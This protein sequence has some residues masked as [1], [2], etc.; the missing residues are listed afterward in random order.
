MVIHVC[1]HTTPTGLSTLLHGFIHICIRPFRFYPNFLFIKESV[2]YA[3]NKEPLLAPY[4]IDNHTETNMI[5]LKIAAIIP[6]GPPI[7]NMFIID[8]HTSAT[9]ANPLMK[10][11]INSLILVTPFITGDA[12]YAKKKEPLLTHFFI[13]DHTKTRM[14]VLSIP[15]TV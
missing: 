6:V 2:F 14:I 13:D 7:L 12:F 11:T 1:L 15:N 8:D 5:A 3:K 10:P 9:L 4:F